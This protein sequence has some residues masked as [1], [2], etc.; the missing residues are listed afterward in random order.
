VSYIPKWVLEPDPRLYITG[1]PLF[2]DF[3]TTNLDKGDPTN[4]HNSLVLACW[5]EGW[6]GEVVAK[7]GNE[8]EQGDLLDAINRCD[9][10]VAHNAKFEIQWLMRCGVSPEKVICYD[11]MLAEYVIGGNRW[12][13]SKLGLDAIMT[14]R[15]MVGK[16]G[17][18]PLMIKAG[19]CPTAIPR[20]WLER[21]CRW[22]VEM[23]VLLM[24]AQLS[25]MEGTRLLPV[26]YSRCLLTPFLADMG[27]EGLQLEHARVAA[28]YDEVKAEYDRCERE[29][30]LITGGI[31]LTSRIQLAVYLYETLGFSELVQRRGGRWEPQR[32]PSGDRMTDADTIAALK[33]ETAA[34]REFLDKFKHYKGLYNKLTKYMNKFVKCCAED[35][36]F[37][38][39]L[40][41][42]TNSTTHRLTST[43]LKYK[44]NFQN[45]ERKLKRLFKARRVGWKIGE[46]D[47]A[48]LEFRFAGHL[49]RDMK[50]LDDAL[51]GADVHAYTASVLT[52]AG[53]ATD[54]QGAK[55]HT[56]KP[57]YGGSSGTPAEQ[58]YYAAF[59]AKYT[60]VAATQQRWIDATLNTK[61]LDTEWGL[62]Y[63]FPDTRMTQSGYVTNT[64]S[65]CNYPV[66]A[67]AT[68]EFIPLAV[69]WAW[70]RIKRTCA[71]RIV[72]VNTIHDSIVGEVAPGAE[73]LWVDVMNEALTSGGRHMIKALY[74]IDLLCT[75]GCGVKLADYWGE[76][77][78]LKYQEVLPCK[79]AA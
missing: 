74:G 32:T 64:P 25:D 60:E 62:I 24:R 41:N 75:L 14:R 48:Q 71:D 77:E 55:P 53:Q 21:Y 38:Q 11:T 58:A 51:K 63:Y 66:Q 46:G 44:T 18:A 67:F 16:T 54:R 35:G 7:W 72:L 39:G 49:C 20:E 30:N 57:L 19:V 45:I 29:L 15:R 1:K 73:E 4:L 43:G 31:S 6:D 47:G 42:Q 34:Q 37:L 36:G 50:V 2:L 59:K 68:A 5:K 33:A 61:Q 12:I 27:F 8:F 76:G 22:D 26:T 52:A 13:F 10:I 9:F 56:F 40:I 65:I 69:V 70:H 28:L 17:P 78:E 3:E 79:L 23:L